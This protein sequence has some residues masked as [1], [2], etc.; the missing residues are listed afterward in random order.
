MA[1]TAVWCGGAMARTRGLNTPA[2][3]RQHQ[4]A[5]AQKTGDLISAGLRHGS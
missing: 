4:H 1:L 3:I 2:Q 5:K